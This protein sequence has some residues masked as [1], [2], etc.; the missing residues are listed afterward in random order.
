MKSYKCT[1][2]GNTWESQ[3]M[4]FECP[5][6]HSAAITQLGGDN[7]MMST[8]KKYWWIIAAAVVAAVIL[9]VALPNGATRVKVKTDTETGRMEVTLKGKHASEYRVILEQNGYVER[10]DSTDNNNPVVFFDLYG[11]YTLKISYK[12]TGNVPRIR[13]FKT[14]YSFDRVSNDVP[15]NSEADTSGFVPGIDVINDEVP[16]TDRPEFKDL[17]ITPKRIKKGETYT[18]TVL[19]SPHGPGLDMVQFSLDGVKYQESNVFAGLTPGNYTIYAK[20]KKIENLISSTE[21]A[22]EEPFAGKC[23]SVKEINDLLPKIYEGDNNARTKLMS[24]LG[25]DTKLIDAKTN[26]I[27]VYSTVS[28]WINQSVEVDGVEHEVISIDC[29]DGKV[30]SVTIKKL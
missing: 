11:E 17:S 14:E 21:I 12:G 24:K 6:C 2:C 23:P 10:E 30:N 9:I 8:L 7:N 18:I 20:N 13:K 5:K 28:N 26:G 29:D 19:L 25:R 4:P 3:E 22:L 16:K 15:S 1:N 27:S